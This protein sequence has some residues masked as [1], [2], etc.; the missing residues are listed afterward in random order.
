MGETKTNRF[1]I[2][3]LLLRLMELYHVSGQSPNSFLTKNKDHIENYIMNGYGWG[4]KHCDVLNDLSQQPNFLD[5][6]P[7]FVMD[8]NMLDRFNIR[9]SLSSS[10]C[11]IIFCH[12]NS[13]QTLTDLIKFGWSVVQHRRL[14]LVLTLSQGMTLEMATNITKLPF[15][16]A[17]SRAGGKEQFLCPV[18]GDINPHLQDTRCDVSHSSYKNKTL[19]VGT[20]GIPPYMYGKL[21]SLTAF[22]KGSF[23]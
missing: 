19:R 18:I 7:K 3:F 15:Q 6:S 14:A 1:I 23:Q 11:L 9:K 13:N 5:E 10:Y 8:I 2:Y 20:F 21:T 16:V 22:F 12:V 4:W 17:A